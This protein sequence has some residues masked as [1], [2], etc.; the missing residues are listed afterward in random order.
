MHFNMNT[1]SVRQ[2]VLSVSVPPCDQ[3]TDCNYVCSQ[4]IE[5]IGYEIRDNFEDLGTVTS[6]LRD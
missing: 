5:D 3:N 4:F 6:K 2:N 1:L